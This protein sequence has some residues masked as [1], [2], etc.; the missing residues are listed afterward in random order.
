M[1]NA[2]RVSL[3]ISVLKV[4]NSV[5][6]NIHVKTFKAEKTNSQSTKEPPP[7]SYCSIRESARSGL[8]VVFSNE[9][10][11]LYQ[12]AVTMTF[13]RSKEIHSNSR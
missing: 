7:H 5:Q 6:V 2:V 3:S 13:E 12:W 11:N 10:G 8:D 1:Y 4:C 9:L